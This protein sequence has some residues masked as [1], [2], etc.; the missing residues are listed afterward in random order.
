MPV[1]VLRGKVGRYGS[2]YSAALWS[3]A[4]LAP[5]EQPR[6]HERSGHRSEI[7]RR[8]EQALSRGRWSTASCQ[9]GNRS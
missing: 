5:K 1:S 4:S 9:L 8:A 3:D 7:Q 2:T 6:R